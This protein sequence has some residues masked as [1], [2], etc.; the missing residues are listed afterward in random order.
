M[1][2]LINESCDP[3]QLLESSNVMLNRVVLVEFDQQED[4]E[5]WEIAGARKLNQIRT[6]KTK[7]LSSDNNHLQ[8]LA[9]HNIQS[10][11][12]YSYFSFGRAA[13]DIKPRSN[14][15]TF[16][17]IET[18]PSTRAVTNSKVNERNKHSYLLPFKI[19]FESHQKPSKIQVLNALVTYNNRLNVSTAFYSK[20]THS[21]HVLFLF[22]NDLSTYELLFKTGT[23]S[24][25]I[26]NSSFMVTS[27]RHIP[28]EWTMDTIQPL[29]AERYISTAHISQWSTN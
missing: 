24:T 23:W 6:T 22:I 20:Q 29:I 8:P 16:P 17:R 28:R 13:L 1:Q 14:Q 2:K 21:Q 19:D 12:A 25:L 27:P 15:N 3:E 11:E 26:C 18:Q 7:L 4:D 10:K 9:H 5:N